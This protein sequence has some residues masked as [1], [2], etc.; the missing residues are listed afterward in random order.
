MMKNSVIIERK[1]KTLSKMITRSSDDVYASHSGWICDCGDWT[2]GDDR[3]HI[4]FKRG[5]R[6]IY[7]S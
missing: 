4:P 6:E 3:N 5:S 1:C 7:Q 2:T